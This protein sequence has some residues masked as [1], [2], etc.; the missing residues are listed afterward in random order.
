MPKR[1][2]VQGRQGAKSTCIHGVGDQKGCSFCDIMKGRRGEGAAKNISRDSWGLAL[3][4][5]ARGAPNGVKTEWT[6]RGAI[7]EGGGW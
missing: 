7:A 6:G 4:K 1:E 2:R 3:L 5:K